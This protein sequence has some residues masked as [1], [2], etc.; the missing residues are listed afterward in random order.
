MCERVFDAADTLPKLILH[1]GSDFQSYKETVSELQHRF[2][3]YKVGVRH[4]GRLI[5][6]A[7]GTLVGHYVSGSWLMGVVIGGFLVLLQPVFED[8]S[9]RIA[10]GIYGFVDPSSMKV[11]ATIEQFR[12]KRSE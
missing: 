2:N 10:S 1:G 11:L 4:G 8:L 7:L 3:S 9:S 12:K 6:F 5:H